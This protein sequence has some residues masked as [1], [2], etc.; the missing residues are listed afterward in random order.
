MGPTQRL[1]VKRLEHLLA[2]ADHLA[3]WTHAQGYLMS[4]V[5]PRAAPRPADGP[6]SLARRESRR[7]ERRVVAPS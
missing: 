5:E 6:V 4:G 1:P 3:A 2:R 7:Q